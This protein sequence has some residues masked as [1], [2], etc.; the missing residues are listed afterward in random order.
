MSV[1]RSS[2]PVVELLRTTTNRKVIDFMVDKDP[3][4]GFRR[5]EIMDT[6]GLSRESLSRAIGTHEGWGP[7]YLFGIVDVPN[8]EASMPR[9]HRCESEVM[10]FLEANESYDFGQWFEL[11]TRQ[12]LTDFFLQRADPDTDYTRY[13]IVEESGSS[14]PGV[15]NNL[16]DYVEA[17][18]ITRHEADE[19]ARADEYFRLNE[20]SDVLNALYVYN[21][22]LY[23][24]YEQRL[25]D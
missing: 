17:N 15:D 3:D 4:E 10:A 16:D 19:G 24:T 5:T 2:L 13:K 7:L 23:E 14:Y 6:V 22:L 21:E 12:K 11:S 18:M 8:P 9:V 20:D 1:S 25:E